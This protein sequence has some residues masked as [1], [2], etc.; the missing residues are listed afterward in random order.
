MDLVY[1]LSMFLAVIFICVIFVILV[2]NFHVD[3]G[4]AKY[5]ER[6]ILA[7]GNGYKYAF[8]A[9]MIASLLPAVIPDDIL[10]FLG[11]VIYFVPL[12]VGLMIYVSYCIWN[13]AYLELN[14]K[15]KTWIV[16]MIFIGLF[17]ALMF[18]AHFKT[19]Y[20]EDGVLSISAVN[21]MMAIMCFVVLL[22][23]IIKG[24]VDKKRE[25]DEDEET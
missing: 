13:D 12:F 6:Q 17:N 11:A 9:T 1:F 23:L 20:V 5:D 4:K 10:H 21:L 15:K 19:G 8:Y 2:R 16:Y 22:E 25:A 14:L 3:G 7:R 24:V 18:F